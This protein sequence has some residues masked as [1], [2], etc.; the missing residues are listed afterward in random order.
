MTMGIYT[1]TRMHVRLHI[2]PL[3]PPILTPQQFCAVEIARN[4]LGLNDAAHELAIREAE[5]ERKQKEAEKERAK[6]GKGKRS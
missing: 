5:K 2:F 3:T 6:K 1:V 4:R